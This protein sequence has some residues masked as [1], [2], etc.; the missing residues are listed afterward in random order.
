L[1][2]EAAGCGSEVV[3]GNQTAHNQGGFYVQ[4]YYRHTLKSISIADVTWGSKFPEVSTA[5]QA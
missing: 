1:F 4:N 3:W 2:L 5:V